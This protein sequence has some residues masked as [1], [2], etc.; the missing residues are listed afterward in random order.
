M[1]L[2][3]K[4]HPKETGLAGVGRPYRSVDIK[5]NKQIIGTIHAPNYS[6]PDNKWS[7]MIAVLVPSSENC[8]WSWSRCPRHFNNEQEARIGASEYVDQIIKSGLKLHYFD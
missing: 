3:F 7:I 4:K 6:T 1:K 8:P 5:H 2:T